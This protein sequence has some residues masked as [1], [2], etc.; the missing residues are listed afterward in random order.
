MISQGA[1]KQACIVCLASEPSFQAENVVKWSRLWT[2]LNHDP[3]EPH[4][5]AQTTEAEPFSF[6][7]RQRKVSDSTGTDFN[8]VSSDQ[9]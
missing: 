5:E 1:G 2:D 6:R 3:L 7:E 9:N 4:V 8:H